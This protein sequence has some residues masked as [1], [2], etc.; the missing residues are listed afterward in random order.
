[1]EL[2][3]LSL[4]YC[5][6]VNNDRSRDY[7]LSNV[8]MVNAQPSILGQQPGPMMASNPQYSG[9]QF[10]PTEQVGMPQNSAGWATGAPPVPQSMAMPMAMPG[11][12]YMPPGAMPPHPGMRHPPGQNGPPQVTMAP[13]RP[14]GRQ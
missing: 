12:P 11:H 3:D 9:A 4:M 8:P 1:M 7:T 10:A 6:Q 13:Y 2:G 5:L 14:D